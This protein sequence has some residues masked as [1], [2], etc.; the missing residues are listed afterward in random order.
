MLFDCYDVVN[1]TMHIITDYVLVLI[2]YTNECGG[3][4]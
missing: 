1:G 3:A 4:L 2:T